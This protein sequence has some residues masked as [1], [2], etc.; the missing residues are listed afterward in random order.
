MSNDPRSE[1]WVGDDIDIV[2]KVS[3]SPTLYK[4]VKKENKVVSR[5]AHSVFFDFDDDQVAPIYAILNYKKK[6]EGIVYSMT[7]ASDVSI[8]GRKLVIAYAVVSKQ[9]IY[10]Y[11][12][13][14]LRDALK[15]SVAQK[16]GIHF[17]SGWR[18]QQEWARESINDMLA[19]Y[20]AG[21]L[22]L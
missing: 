14:A 1:Y 22:K 17:L 11:S 21:R 13:T 2:T 4:Q 19:D 18:E 10:H 16:G 12:E 8:V 3:D 9:G 7:L 20:R 5:P 15:K 6:D